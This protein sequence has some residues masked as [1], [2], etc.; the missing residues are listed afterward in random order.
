MNLDVRGV[1]Y[2]LGEKLQEYIERRLRFAL[3]RFAGRIDRVQ[4]RI[5]DINGPRGGIDK[6]CQI[7]VA[8]IPRGEVR[9]EGSDH[10]PFALVARVSKRAAYAVHRT[11]GRRRRARVCV[12]SSLV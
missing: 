3:R 8:L 6:R 7:T 11:L 1:K 10:D 9:V 2:E 12:R 5:S 4:V